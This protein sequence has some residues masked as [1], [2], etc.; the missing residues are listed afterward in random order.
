MD[1]YNKDSY[2]VYDIK[3]YDVWTIKYRYKVL[4]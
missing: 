4:L 1:E 2:A 3:Y